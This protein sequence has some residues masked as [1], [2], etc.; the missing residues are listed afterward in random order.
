[1]GLTSLEVRKKALKQNV[2]EQYPITPNPRVVQFWEKIEKTKT[3]L[4]SINLVMYIILF[5]Y[6]VYLTGVGSLL[7][8][9]LFF[10]KSIFHS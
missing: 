10:K 6:R 5:I 3:K 2:P 9:F 8:D 7:L 4:K 1:N